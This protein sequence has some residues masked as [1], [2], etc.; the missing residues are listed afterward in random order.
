MHTVW[1]CM[2]VLW[3]YNLSV[4][5]LEVFAHAYSIKVDSLALELWQSYDCPNAMPVKKPWKLSIKTTYINSNKKDV[6]TVLNK[7]FRERQ[8]PSAPRSV[9]E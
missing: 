9:N 4:G 3:S 6:R 1:L 8:H 5:L 7:A 2:V